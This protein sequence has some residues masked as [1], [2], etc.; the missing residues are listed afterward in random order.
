MKT[1][2]YVGYFSLAIAFMLGGCAS[3]APSLVKLNPS[4]P[5][6]AKAVAGD[7][8]L[9]VD[10]YATVERSQR[11]FDTDMANEGVLPLLLQVENSGKQ[12]YE[13][14]TS[15]ILLRG[16]KPLKS[17]TAEETAGKAGRSAVGRA[18]GWSLI[19]PIISIPVAV[20]ASAIH[21]SKVNDQIVHDLVAKSFSDGEI[22]PNKERSGFVFFELEDGA[23]ELSKLTLELTARN[24]DTGE[25]LKIAT[26]LPSKT[27]K[28]ETQVQKQ[29]GAGEVTGSE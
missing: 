18:L 12:R 6:V 24:I 9:Y 4:G 15:N 20:A 10:E 14:K 5:N 17:L 7:L 22:M 8:T 13:V 3:Y 23:I 27:V 26:A 28:S 16:D 25:Q 19:V 21:T 29:E 1:H 11:A 2:Q